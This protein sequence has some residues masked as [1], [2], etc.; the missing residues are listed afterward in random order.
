MK[1]ED[2]V[3]AV[4]F[5]PDGKT[6]ITGSK[7]GTARFWDASTGRPLG[8]PLTRGKVSALA[9]S[10]DGRTVMT[11]GDDGTA[12]L[13]SASTSRPLG[14]PLMHRAAVWAVA[15]SPDGKTVIT[16]GRDGTI[17][18]WDA[19]AELPDDLDRVANWVEAL[20]GLTLDETGS[21]RVIDNAA[22]LERREKVK[23]QGGPPVKDA[24]R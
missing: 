23:R 14:P 13:W 5:S 12:R 18:H 2:G 17:R 1:H 24:E 7:D 19:A 8:P 20:T 4:A 16:G 15:F 6:V 9:F 10:R 21:I 11:G 3:N 22:W